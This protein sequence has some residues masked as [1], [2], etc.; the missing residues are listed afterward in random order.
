MM[1][2]LN[3]CSLGMNGMEWVINMAIY[4]YPFSKKQEKEEIER[5]EKPQTIEPMQDKSLGQEEKQIQTGYIKVTVKNLEGTPLP[6]TVIKLSRDGQEV[7]KITTDQ[8]GEYKFE[9][10]EPGRY[11][12][13]VWKQ[14][15][16]VQEKTVEL[17]N[18][19]LSINILLKK[20][21]KIK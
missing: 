12:I 13:K 15:Y 20:G 11:I 2:N 21:A 7:K 1:I 16:D 8:T 3:S 10:L 18:K 9:D 6:K 14:G 5:T 19:P 17:T 4:Y